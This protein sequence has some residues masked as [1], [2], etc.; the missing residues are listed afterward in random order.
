MQDYPSIVETQ[1]DYNPRCLRRDLSPGAAA[2]FTLENLHNLTLGAA[3]VSIGKMQYEFQGADGSLRMHGAGH[4]SMGGDG[5]DVFTSREYIPALCL[6]LLLVRQPLARCSC[7]CRDPLSF[8]P[9]PG[10][11]CHVSEV[12]LER[13][14]LTRGM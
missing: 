12:R 1:L 4:Y 2:V 3:S 5:A 13:A 8:W 6:S 14:M 11:N 10:L 9:W 7:W